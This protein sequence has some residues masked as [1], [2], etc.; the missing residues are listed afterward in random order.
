MKSEKLETEKGNRKL[1][2]LLTFRL[3][4]EKPGRDF[5]PCS[6]SFEVI[7]FFSID[8]RNFHLQN[9]TTHNYYTYEGEFSFKESEALLITSSTSIF[10]VE[11]LSSI[12]RFSSCNI[13]TDPFKLFQQIQSNDIQ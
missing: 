7:E 5:C 9:K 10:S 2:S 13:S 12:P 1:E 11:S 6:F 3:D 4:N 8:K